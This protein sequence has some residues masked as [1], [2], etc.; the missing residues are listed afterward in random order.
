MQHRKKVNVLDVNIKKCKEL[1][2]RLEQ[3]SFGILSMYNTKNF[4]HD[5]QTEQKKNTNLNQLQKNIW[6]R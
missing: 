5:N 2:T 3:T 6:P 1:I 4:T